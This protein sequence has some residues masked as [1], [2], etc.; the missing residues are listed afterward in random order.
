MSITEVY[1]IPQVNVRLQKV[2][3]V[4]YLEELCRF[5]LIQHHLLFRLGTPVQS[6]SAAPAGLLSSPGGMSDVG[7]ALTKPGLP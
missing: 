3:E 2:F 5:S 1:H 6:A 4:Q 7:S